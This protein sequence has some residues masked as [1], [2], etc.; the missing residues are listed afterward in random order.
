MEYL[1]AFGTCGREKHC[2][3]DAFNMNSTVKFR[4]SNPT[5][6]LAKSLNI[7]ILLKLHLSIPRQTNSSNRSAWTWA[8][9]RLA[10]MTR[11]AAP[12]VALQSMPWRWLTRWPREMDCPPRTLLDFLLQ[13]PGNQEMK[14]KI[15]RF[16][17]AKPYPSW[18]ALFWE[19]AR[20]K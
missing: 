1:N 20:W 17:R 13:A 5:R 10:A 2:M 12:P 8:F 6:V 11:L 15:C 3:N 18:N 4:F 19:S 16:F 14:Q 9:V 7:V